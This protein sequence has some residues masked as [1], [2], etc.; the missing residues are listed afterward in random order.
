MTKQL[1][2]A[3]KD[4]M[5]EEKCIVGTKQVLGSL[6]NSKLVVFSTSVPKDTLKKIQNAAKNEKVTTLDYGGSSVALAKLCGLHFRV[7]SL[8]LTSLNNTNL[9]SIL[10]E[11]KQDVE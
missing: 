11:S 9:E 10:K 8:S 5:E 1:E 3:V 2:K 7:S 4:A 6:K